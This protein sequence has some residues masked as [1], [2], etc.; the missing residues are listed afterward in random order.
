MNPAAPWAIPV[1]TVLGPALLE[2]HGD[3]ISA[4]GW[5]D[6]DSPAEGYGSPGS[7]LPHI[8]EALHAAL[9]GDPAGW[10]FLRHL[11]LKLEGT[12]FQREVWAAL[13]DVPFGTTWTYGALARH[14]RHGPSLSRAVGAA[15]GRN[16]VALFIPCHRIVSTTG[17]LA[18]FRWG[19]SRK[20]ALL[21]L[22]HPKQMVLLP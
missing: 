19:L 2:G 5:H 6:D 16:R 7:H 4:F 14:L 1:E 10:D 15:C 20:K 9:A 22:E 11:P 3:Q 17:K 8:L 21:E 13:R 18:G 12:P